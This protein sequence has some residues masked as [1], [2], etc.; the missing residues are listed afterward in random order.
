MTPFS[1]SVEYTDGL[2]DNPFLGRE[3]D[4]IFPVSA[5]NHD[6]PYPTP[7]FTM[8]LDKKFITPTCRTGI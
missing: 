5:N 6:V 1:Y 7:L 4:N 2:F 8:V 3:T